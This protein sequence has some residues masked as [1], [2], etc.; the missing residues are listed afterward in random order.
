MQCMLLKVSA[1]PTESPC[2]RITIAEPLAGTSHGKYD[3]SANTGRP[4]STGTAWSLP[5]VR[6]SRGSFSGPPQSF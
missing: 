6:R 1:R 4:Q 2:L 3:L 5:A